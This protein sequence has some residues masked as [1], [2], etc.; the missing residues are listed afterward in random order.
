MRTGRDQGYATVVLLVL[1]GL[2]VVLCAVVAEVGAIAAA[3]VKASTAADLAALAAA[4]QVDCSATPDVARGNGAELMTCEVE[5]GDVIVS[6]RVPVRLVGGQM[7]V[8][9]WSRAGP[10]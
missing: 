9:A 2:T 3:R 1:M 5:G 7:F 10:P 6:V 8:T 4:R